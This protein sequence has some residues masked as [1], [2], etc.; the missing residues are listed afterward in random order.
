MF[1]GMLPYA[2]GQPTL[3]QGRNPMLT[4]IH[5]MHRGLYRLG[6]TMGSTFLFGGCW[7]QELEDGSS[8]ASVQR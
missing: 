4:T 8:A 7:Q 3:P 5:T 6:Q 1:A 2:Q